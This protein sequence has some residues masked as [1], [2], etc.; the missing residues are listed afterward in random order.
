MTMDM[1]LVYAGTLANKLD[2][3][4]WQLLLSTVATTI[5]I[6]LCCL[7][8][9]ILLLFRMKYYYGFY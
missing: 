4:D 9:M 1:A 7:V 5:G 3:Q 2:E 8:K 6:Y